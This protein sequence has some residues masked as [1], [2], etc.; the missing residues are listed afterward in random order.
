MPVI[1]TQLQQLSRVEDLIFLLENASRRS[2]LVKGLGGAEYAAIVT[3][4]QGIIQQLQSVVAEK[5]WVGL[6]LT[7]CEVS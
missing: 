6:R 5:N 4:V 3:E 1:R 2:H 7:A